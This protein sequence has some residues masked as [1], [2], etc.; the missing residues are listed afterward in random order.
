MNTEDIGSLAGTGVGS[1]MR[2][3]IYS[4]SELNR[5]VKIH[6]ESGFPRI[7]LEG[8]ISNLS[9]PGSGHMYFSLKDNKAQV[10]CALF[11]S[12]AKRVAA[13][14]ENGLKVLVSARISLY[15][16]RGEY[17]LII[18]SLEHAGAGLLQLKFEKLKEKLKTEGLFDPARRK[19]LPPYPLRI[20]LVTSSTGAAVRDMLNV[21][22]RRWPVAS[23]RIYPVPVQGVEAPMAIVKALDAA[24]RHAWGQVVL[25]GRGGGSLEDLWAFNEEPVARAIASCDIPL[26]SAVGHE[27]DFTIADFVADI[28]AATPSAA[29]ELCAPDAATLKRAFSAFEQR[30]SG[31]VLDRCQAMAQKLDHLAH[32]LTQAHPR[33]RLPDQERKLRDQAARAQKALQWQIER[34]AARLSQT[35]RQ[36]RHFHPGRGLV[37]ASTKIQ[38]IAVKLREQMKRS[39]QDRQ[40]RLAGLANTLHAIS[41]LQTVGRGYALITASSTGTLITS[42]KQV[43][44]DRKLTAQIRDGQFLCTVDS[45]EGRSQH[46]CET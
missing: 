10:R 7:L 36:L 3:R 15:E 39:F 24:Q 37:M 33:R 22:R 4:P 41:P 34:S 8:E 2:Q 21:L 46:T 35:R 17:Q 20:A 19:P 38:T 40:S 1:G 31:R 42:V 30:L 12:A 6:L 32:R 16:A 9:R 18:D 43:P 27:T 14:P 25:L 28:R 44:G 23:V 26:I 11:R 5:E 13:P 45:V 29:A